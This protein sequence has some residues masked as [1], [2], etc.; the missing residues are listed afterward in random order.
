MWRL[1]TLKNLRVSYDEVESQRRHLVSRIYSLG[2]KLGVKL[3]NAKS[4]NMVKSLN[5]KWM[6]RNSLLMLVWILIP[7]LLMTLSG[8]RFSISIALC[9]AVL[10]QWLPGAL[11]WVW[12]RASHKI[13]GPELL[14]MGLAIGTL[15][16][17]FESQLLRTTRYSHLSWI[18]SIFVIS[19]IITLL[20]LSNKKKSVG[21][22]S[23]TIQDATFFLP[24]IIIGLI[25]ISSWWRWNPLN[26][27]GWWKFQIDVPYIESYSNSLAL[28]GT[29]QS[30]MSPF[31]NSRYHW[32]AYAWIGEINNSIKVEPFV[33]M[34]RVFPIVALVMAGSLAYSWANRCTHIRWIPPLATLV[35]VAGPGLSIGS[36]VLLQSPGSAMTTGWSIAFCLVLFEILNNNINRPRYYFVLILLAIGIVGGKTSTGIIMSG[37]IA[38]M[39]LVVFFQ[40]HKTKRQLIFVLILPLITFAMT[41]QVL[42]SSSAPRPLQVGVFLGWPGLFL[43]AAPFCVGLYSLFR[44]RLMDFE[45]ILIFALSISILGSFGSLLTHDSSGN[46]IY[47]LCSAAAIT[48]VPSLVG[49]DRLIREI[50]FRSNES[51]SIVSENMSRIKII[52]LVSI[53]SGVFAALIWL[54]F[55]S[56]ISLMGNFGRTLSPFPIWIICI[57][58]ILAFFIGRESLQNLSNYRILVFALSLMLSTLTSSLIYSAASHV[59][60]PIYSNG[61]TL[62]RYGQ[63]SEGRPGAISKSYFRAGEWVQDN[64]TTSAKFFTNRQCMDST[65]RYD[66]CDGLWFYASALTK[67]QFIVEGFTY[68]G[69]LWSQDRQM[70]ELQSASLRFSLEP[71]SSDLKL[72]WR[73]GVRWGWIDHQISARTDWKGMAEIE[74]S[75]DAV[76]VIKLKAP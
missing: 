31:Q 42:I 43:T 4:K 5:L 2:A 16:S 11:I 56:S 48:V 46:Q 53:F 70:N 19:P 28:L 59:K 47:F 7:T 33:V 8:A 66:D 41:F 75:N 1:L 25:Q 57:L 63:S 35:M 51:R 36:F 55:E 44:F 20:I 58:A 62:I 27:S 71:N 15:L 26:W 76:D 29:T 60:G 13:S 12:V 3:N 45:P 54:Y 21:D 72:L 61:S 73:Y 14:G 24:A 74:F 17:I 32:F 68:S 50:K 30:F 64:I 37:G 39:L 69:N 10:A 34:T 22:K 38:I 6:F 52:T 67:R 49:I 18:L 9:L 65:E 23:L 40:N